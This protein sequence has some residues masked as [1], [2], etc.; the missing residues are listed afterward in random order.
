M[1]KKLLLCWG[2]ISAIPTP[3]Y[4]AVVDFVPRIVR[5]SATLTVD[6]EYRSLTN[7]SARSGDSGSTRNT[8]NLGLQERVSLRTTGYVY[9]PNLLLFSGSISGME[10]STN[11]RSTVGSGA[12]VSGQE[13]K[14]SGGYSIDGDVLRKKPFY[15]EFSSYLDRPFVGS[16]LSE[17]MSRNTLSLNYVNRPFV[18]LLEYVG[19]GRSSELRD[20]NDDQFRGSVSYAGPN[21]TV[22]LIAGH[23]ENST[24]V[25]VGA[26]STSKVE[27]NN[28]ILT[29]QWSYNALDSHMDM[30]W[31]T[32]DNGARKNTAT[33]AQEVLD[34]ELPWNF[35]MRLNLS[36]RQN[37]VSVEGGAGST[38]THDQSMFR[39]TQK[40][41][42]SLRSELFTEYQTDKSDSGS[43]D[44]FRYRIATDYTKKLRGG[45]VNVGT[46]YD[47]VF[48]ESAGRVDETTSFT[49]AV[50]GPDIV[51]SRSDIDIATIKIYLVVN[52]IPYLLAPHEH[53]EFVSSGVDSV[54]IAL[55]GDDVSDVTSLKYFIHDKVPGQENANNVYRVEFSTT[56]MDYLLETKQGEAYAGITLLEGMIGGQYRHRY[57]EQVIA[58]GDQ[59]LSAGIAPR[60]TDDSIN[61]EWAYGPFS[62]GGEYSIVATNY[63]AEKRVQLLS[64]DPVISEETLAYVATF[65]KKLVVIPGVNSSFQCNYHQTMYDTELYNH[66]TQSAEN[67][68]GNKYS[69]DAAANSSVNFP[70]LKAGL[71]HSMRFERMRGDYTELVYDKRNLAVS[72]PETTDDRDYFETELRSYW[73][74]PRTHV[75]L[76][77]YVRY[78]NEQ[79][80]GGTQEV[81]TKYGF[82]SGYRWSLGATALDLKGKYSMETTDVSGLA[83]GTSTT[84]VEEW[85]VTLNMIRRLF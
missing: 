63:D 74:L 65:I 22:Q 21:Y 45:G 52:S 20:S 50:G 76:N 54:T 73:T 53:W 37:E 6:G 9:H 61:V 66:L 75:K 15:A 85:A 31:Q 77:G 71:S 57:T 44:S 69:F 25:K 35:D 2:A 5:T 42:E 72:N 41:F 24:E 84:S 12:A 1:K 81:N 48:F 59:G 55:N 64:S 51:V 28:A 43:R 47:A 34:V 58:D 4:G 60:V 16:T 46:S 39:M 70:S 17:E 8:K 26:K 83:R 82:N 67:I 18:S 49:A 10:S 13:K 14:Q 30:S 3:V 40:L 78:E 23:S 38:D 36:R 79:Y 56:R 11:T 80:V 33:E 32:V 7:K 27:S 62:L 68:N 19:N 29:N